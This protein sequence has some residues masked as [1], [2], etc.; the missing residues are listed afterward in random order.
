MLL[1]K[2]FKSHSIMLFLPQS[3]PGSPSHFGKGQTEEFDFVD[4]EGDMEGVD[5]KT[6][7]KKEPGVLEEGRKPL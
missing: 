1:K 5:I 6:R 4:V 3:Q 2:S 7:V